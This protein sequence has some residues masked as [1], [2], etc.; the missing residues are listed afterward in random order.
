MSMACAQRCGLMS[1]V[2]QSFAGD[3]KGVGSTRILGRIEVRCF[4]TNVVLCGV[5]IR[6]LCAY[7]CPIYGAT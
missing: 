5:S 3:A 4:L 6:V 1:L 7:G 2:D